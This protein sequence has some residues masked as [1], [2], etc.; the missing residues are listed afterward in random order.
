[1]PRFAVL[2]TT[3][4]V[5]KRK[6]WSDGTLTLSSNVYAALYGEGGHE[7][8]TEKVAVSARFEVHPPG[9][10]VLVPFQSGLPHG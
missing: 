7:I 1:M 10:P 2:Y 3:D 4:L 8:G 5:K 9:P 6:R